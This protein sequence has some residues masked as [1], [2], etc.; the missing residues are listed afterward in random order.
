V[1]VNWFIAWGSCACGVGTVGVGATTVADLLF[2]G[3]GGTPGA[4]RG[5]PGGGGG[6]GRFPAVAM[7]G[8]TG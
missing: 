2:G 4:P 8:V 5:A 6:G 1:L 7:L 3:G